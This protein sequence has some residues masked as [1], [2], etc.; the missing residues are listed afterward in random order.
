M[1][2]VESIIY[3][4]YRTNSKFHHNTIDI[5][6][7]GPSG[8][9]V[10]I[11][12]CLPEPKAKNNAQAHKQLLQLNW[13]TLCPAFLQKISLKKRCQNIFVVAEWSRFYALCIH[14]CV[15]LNRLT[16]EVHIDHKIYISM[17][18][19]PS[20]WRWN[21]CKHWLLSSRLLFLRLCV[22]TPLGGAAFYAQRVDQAAQIS[23]QS[24]RSC[25]HLSRLCQCIYWL[26]CKSIDKN[27]HLAPNGAI[28]IHDCSAS[29][30]EIL[31][32]FLLTI[33]SL[34]FYVFL[35]TRRA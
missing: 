26:Q 13:I 6:I 23:S 11:C 32:C 5:F 21:E 1:I 18:C 25:H 30:L 29:I 7:S 16:C 28:S 24:C 12:I 33:F 27:N 8:N 22:L 31:L 19:I 9:N 14:N 10:C 20:W 4:I 35:A 3:K 2:P 17:P 15:N 34:N